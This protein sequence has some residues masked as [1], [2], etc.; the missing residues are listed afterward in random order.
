MLRQQIGH[1]QNTINPKNTFNRFVIFQSL[2]D[3][4]HT[5][6]I[7]RNSTRKQKVTVFEIFFFEIHTFFPYHTLLRLG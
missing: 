3:K 4:I 7:Q 6:R 1:C 2:M 5:T